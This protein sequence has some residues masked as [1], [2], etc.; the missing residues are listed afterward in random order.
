MMLFDLANYR[1]ARRRT[2]QMIKAT[3]DWERTEGFIAD[4]I[5]CPETYARQSVRIL[6]VL[7]E[8]YGY[9]ECGEV[10]VEGQLTGDVLGVG[11]PAVRSSRGLPSLLWLLHRSWEIGRAVTREEF[12]GLFTVNDANTSLLQGTLAK[13]GW[14]NV[15][16]ASRHEG[17]RMDPAEVY[18]HGVRN[19]EILREQIE[20]ICPDLMIV[21]GAVVS[22]AL[23]GLNL[24]G[25]GAELGRKWRVQRTDDGRW[26]LEVCHPRNWWGYEKL[27]QRFRGVHEQLRHVQP[28]RLPPR[29]SPTAAV[30]PP[31]FTGG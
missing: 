5:I 2:V 23:H 27:Y 16:K 18:D 21:C 12:P 7:A 3:H 14:L 29:P 19:R 13:V 25:T 15:K 30:A 28:G 22:R 9:A 8:S 6:C 17:T 10:D 11:N 1:D 4:G 20:A 24:L 26:L 31:G